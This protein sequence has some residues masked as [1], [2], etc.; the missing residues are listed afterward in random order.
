MS[1]P[2]KKLITSLHTL[3]NLR[4]KLLSSKKEKGQWILK[5]TRAADRLTDLQLQSGCWILIKI[6]F[7]SLLYHTVFSS[8]LC[9][10]DLGGLLIGHLTVSCCASLPMT[11]IFGNSRTN[12]ADIAFEGAPKAE[13]QKRLLNMQYPR[14]LDRLWMSS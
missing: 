8:L 3:L 14:G 1:H 2:T 4:K 12:K 9:D 7:I 5:P 10:L 13:C 11:S 6:P